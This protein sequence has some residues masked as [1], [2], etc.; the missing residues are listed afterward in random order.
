MTAAILLL[1]LGLGLIVA[2]VF[3]PSLGLLAVLATA[4]IVGA[5]VMAFQESSAAGMRFL[6][7]TAVLVRQSGRKWTAASG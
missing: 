7:A 5:L 4:A 6:L 1:V 3:F 2:E